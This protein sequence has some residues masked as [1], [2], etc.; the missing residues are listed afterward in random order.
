MPQSDSPLPPDPVPPPGGATPGAWAGR[1]R[2]VAAAAFVVA[3]VFLVRHQ[4]GRPPRLAGDAWEYWYQAESFDRHG[5]PDLRPDDRAAVDAAAARAGQGPAP[6]EAYA[7]AAAPDGRLY[8]VHF[9]SYALSAVPAKMYLRLTGGCELA[10]LLAA[11]AGWFALAVGVV[12]F[13][14]KAPVGERVALAGLAAVGPAVWYLDWPGAELFCWALVLIAVAAFRDRRDGLAGAAAGLAATQNPTAVFLGGVAVVAAAA[15]RRWG[16]AARAAAGTALAFLPFAFFQYHFGKPNLIA[17][18]FATAANLS[19]VRTW[20]SLT[21][22]NQ[23][24]LPYAPLLAVGVVAGAARLAY[25]RNRRGLLLAAGGVAMAVGVEVQHNWNSDCVGLHRYLV[26]M[27]PVAA[28]VVV[29]AFGGRR[30]ALGLAAAGVAVAAHAALLVAADRGDWLN[31][32]YLGH[33]PIAKWVLTHHP[34][35]YWVEP[36]VFVERTDHRD[37]WPLAPVPFPIGFAAADGTVTKMLL[38]AA[39]VGRVGD[40][41]DADP[42]YLAALAARAAGE[43]G[44]FYAHP[45]PGAVRVRPPAP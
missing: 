25:A 18:E 5:T 30:P 41:Y 10:A 19:W 39:S 8:G 38:D 4:A 44:V 34:R 32:G 11:N 29:E 35:A 24:L 23:G 45:P 2:A 9:W 20:G 43:R 7:Y 37:G 26:W 17:A 33:T 21:D 31:E 16:A 12:L 1:V 6:A 28:G 3:A 40:V 13:G 36:E 15:E 42:A 22:L 14:S 27:I